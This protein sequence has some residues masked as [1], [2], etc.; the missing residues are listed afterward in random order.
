M[1]SVALALAGC[2]G[3][4]PPAASPALEAS[5]AAS[6]ST[7]PAAGAT[8]TPPPSPSVRGFSLQAAL[9]AAR[10]AYGAPGALAV[11]S[12]GGTRTFLSSGTADTA[13][14]P[15]TATTR[16]RIASITKPIVAALVLDAVSRGELGLDDVVGSLLPGVLRP[17]PAVTVRQL[18]DHTS[19][20]FDETND[21]STP[22]DIEADIA[23]LSAPALRAEATDTLQRALA[24]DRVVASDRVIVALSETHDRYAPPG[25]AFHYSNTNF[26]LAA[27]LLEK[28]TGRPLADLL[29]TR[30]VGPLGLRHTTIAPPDLAAPE[31]RGYAP[32]DGGTLADLTDDL[33]WLGNGGNGGIVSTAD[34]LLTML[35]AIVAGD[36]LP[37]ALRR[38]ML[39]PVLESYGL[40]IG[41]SRFSCVTG[42]GH[43]G[44]VNGQASIAYVA[45][46]GSRGAVIAMNL[47]KDTDPNLYAVADTLLCA[48]G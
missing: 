40:G 31:M 34:D 16:F 8:A 10:T 6:A 47:R 9:D 45:S 32:A 1:L 3:A 23:R 37:P 13:G 5:P 15:I 19:G 20:I 38:E 11:V 33:V 27:M 21:V 22:A 2:G 41:E 17:E 24:G 18:L 39:T 28:A 12:V 44:G 7:P 25:A 42:W 30:I 26:Q 48:A 36:L 35:E 43:Q 4:T 46:D 29:R 14:T